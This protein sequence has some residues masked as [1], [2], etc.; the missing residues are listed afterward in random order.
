MGVVVVLLV[1]AV[2]LL[3]AYEEISTFWSKDY[4][5]GDQVVTQANG[6]LTMVDPQPPDLLG[7]LLDPL[8]IEGP[9]GA[10]VQSPNT[11]DKN[12]GPHISRPKTSNDSTLW[13]YTGVSGSRT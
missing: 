12:F 6:T 3:C 13:R 1:R 10:T 7:D 5:S 11:L 2:A 8:A 9:P 4:S